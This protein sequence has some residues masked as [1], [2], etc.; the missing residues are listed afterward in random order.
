MLA[1]GSPLVCL[2]LCGPSGSTTGLNACETMLVPAHLACVLLRAHTNTCPCARTGINPYSVHRL[3]RCVNG[4]TIHAD[5]LPK[6]GE[7]M[8]QAEVRHQRTKASSGTKLGGM[9][10]SSCKSRARV[11]HRVCIP[12]TIVRVVRKT[13]SR[14]GCF[15]I[16]NIHIYTYMYI[17]TYIHACMHAYIHTYIHPHT[18]THT[19]THT[20]C[21]SIYLSIYL[22]TYSSYIV[23]LHHPTTLYTYSGTHAHKRNLHA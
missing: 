15:S 14:D 22:S 21:I 23:H 7:A 18:H 16:I 10:I 1:G 17:Y 20:V 5:I 13:L 12:D 11:C 4:A 9:L 2:S 8:V 19:H 3:R 6:K